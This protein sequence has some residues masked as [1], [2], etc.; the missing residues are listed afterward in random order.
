MTVK[1]FPCQSELLSLSCVHLL[2]FVYTSSLLF[3]ILFFILVFLIVV[4]N[5]SQF[6]YLPSSSVL[7]FLNF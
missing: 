4:E 5:A 3:N 2:Q 6:P 1:S 7:K